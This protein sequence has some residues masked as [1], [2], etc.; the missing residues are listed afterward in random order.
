MRVATALAALVVV[1][2]L[3][4]G[5]YAGSCRTLLAV[6]SV[7]V[8][9]SPAGLVLQLSGTWEFDNLLQVSNGLAFS[10]LVVRGDQFVRVQYPNVA[11][12]GYYPGLADD[13]AGGLDGTKIQAIEAA[14]TLEPL[15]RVISM[16]AQKLKIVV[17][18]PPGVGPL[19]VVLY[20]ILDGDYYNPIVG[21]TIT[22]SLKELAA[23]GSSPT[24]DV[25]ALRGAR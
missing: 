16:E 12:S 22:K 21:N 9:S 5:A 1:A 3:G 14:G 20:L 2:G 17:P 4:A 11:Q 23:T 15:A 7:R 13:L 10:I 24:G 18:E 25:K 8:D 19:N 6:G